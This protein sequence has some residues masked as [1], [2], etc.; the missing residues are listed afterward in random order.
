MR[1]ESAVGHCHRDLPA[2]IVTA[3]GD[4]LAARVAIDDSGPRRFSR[5]DNE[6][7][8][9]HAGRQEDR[10]FD[11]FV[12]RLSAALLNNPREHIRRG[13]G[14]PDLATR[15]NLQRRLSN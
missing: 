12:E 9:I 2:G 1:K 11:E 7:C 15:L 8:I 14:V 10:L 3:E 4:S 13:A 6:K 5:W